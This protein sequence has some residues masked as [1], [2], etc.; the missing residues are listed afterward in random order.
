MYDSKSTAKNVYAPREPEIL[1]YASP[2]TPTDD[3]GNG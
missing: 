1:V 2:S 3:E